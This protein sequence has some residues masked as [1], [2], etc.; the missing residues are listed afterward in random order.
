MI[1]RSK[2][3]ASSSSSCSRGWDAG[4]AVEEDASLVVDGVSSLEH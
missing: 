3:G 2:A 4:A 1:T